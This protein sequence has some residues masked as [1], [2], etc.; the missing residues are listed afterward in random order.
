MYPPHRLD[1]EWTYAVQKACHTRKSTEKVFF[2][3]VPLSFKA[4]TVCS[5]V[6]RNG[7]N[8]RITIYGGVICSM[9]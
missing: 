1:V 7:F 5:I 2:A 3:F 9:G 4:V 8:D 6:K